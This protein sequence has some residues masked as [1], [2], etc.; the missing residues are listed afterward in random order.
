MNTYI[1]TW[2]PKEVCLMKNIRILARFEANGLAEAEKKMKE[3][4]KTKTRGVFFLSEE[5]VQYVSHKEEQD[6]IHERAA[7]IGEMVERDWGFS[8]GA[9]LA[10]DEIK[11]NP[12]DPDIEIARAVA[13]RI[14]QP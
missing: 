3:I 2:Q 7:R 1:V 4:R 10:L 5:M 14:G 8:D 9:D 11:L 6:G 13:Q 12:Q